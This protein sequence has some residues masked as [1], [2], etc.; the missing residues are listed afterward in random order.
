VV[1]LVPRELFA[2]ATPLLVEGCMMLARTVWWSSFDV[3]PV[4]WHCFFS[5]GC[6]SESCTP[7]NGLVL[8]GNWAKLS[9]KQTRSYYV[10]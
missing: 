6:W 3:C 10:K 1:E 7:E 2:L 4:I 9:G 8:R 5:G